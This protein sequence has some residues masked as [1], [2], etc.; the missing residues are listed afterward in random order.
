MTPEPL[1]FSHAPF[2]LKLNSAGVDLVGRGEHLAHVVHHAGVGRRI[3]SRGRAHRR[4]IDHDRVGMLAQEH[5]VDERA[6]ARAGDAGDHRQHAGRDVDADVLQ[7]VV[8]RVL[9]RA[10]VPLGCAHVTLD[11]QRLLE[12]RGRQRVG[13][14]QVAIA[15]LEHDSAAGRARVRADVDDVIGDLD[16]V[17]I[18]LDDEHG[19]ALVAQLLQ[20]LVEPVHVARVQADARLVED[21][22]DVDQAAARGA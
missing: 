19:V 15:A 9:D 8:A 7:V 21:V 16:H 6:L 17:G 18:V 4:L 2:E 11:R 20:Q 3:G 12:V 13:T 5:L 1:Q 10:A 22:H 14:Q